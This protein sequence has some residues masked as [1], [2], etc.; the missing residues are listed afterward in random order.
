MSAKRTARGPRAPHWMYLIDA[1]SELRRLG[2]PLYARKVEQAALFIRAK[3]PPPR[4][5]KDA[6]RTWTLVMVV[7]HLLKQ[8]PSAEDRD[9]IA[10]AV[11]AM[12]GKSFERVSRALRR[13]R[14]G[15]PPRSAFASDAELRAAMARLPRTHRTK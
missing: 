10:A 3:A 5:R 2:Q 15:K 1:A 11:G 13:W 14:A 7:L 8:R 12:E 9:A 4:P 6:Q